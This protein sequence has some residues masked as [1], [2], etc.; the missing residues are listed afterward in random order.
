MTLSRDKGFTLIETVIAFAILVLSLPVLYS[1][2]A[3]SLARSR[4]DRYLSEGI[5]L[6]QSLLARAGV[7]RP[8]VDGV[9]RGTWGDYGY[10]LTE[11][12][13]T[14]PLGEE[15]YSMPTVHVNA[16][17]FWSE[18]GADRTIAISTLKLSPRVPR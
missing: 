3:G 8:F 14:A 16:M 6:A 9:E 10:E 15:P 7:E 2:L 17:V 1:A 4:H 18:N 13:L 11:E 12:M 5:L